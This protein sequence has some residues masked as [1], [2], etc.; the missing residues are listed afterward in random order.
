M[1]MEFPFGLASSLSLN[2]CQIS[3]KFAADLSCSGSL[4]Y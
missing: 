3:I 4:D 1:N 2:E